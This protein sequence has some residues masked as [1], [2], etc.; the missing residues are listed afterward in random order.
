MTP[1]VGL[2]RVALQTALIPP[3]K[4]ANVAPKALCW[5]MNAFHMDLEHGCGE[6]SV[7]TSRNIAL[8]LPFT[9]RVHVADVAVEIGASL[10]SLWTVRTLQQPNPVSM[11]AQDVRA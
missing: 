4:I 3:D 2:L 9:V 8:V 7:A 10:E 1:P 11:E 6:R 5:W